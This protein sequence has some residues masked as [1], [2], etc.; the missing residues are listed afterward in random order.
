[1]TKIPQGARA[2]VTGA[3]SGFGRAIALE[4]A[5]RRARVLA[6][7]IDAASL[8]ET[9]SMLRAQGAEA[10]SML[11]DVR[12][13]ARVGA[14][15]E[16]AQEL[17]GGTD[18][19]VNNAGVAVAGEVGEIPLEDWKWQIDINLWGVIHGCHHFVPAMKKQK[20]GWILNVA[21]IAGVTSAP[22]MSP[23]NVTKA[24]VIALSE[25]LATEL[26]S[27]RI[28]VTALCPSFFRTNIHKTTR[29]HRPDAQGRT[30]KLVTEARWGA[31][32]IAR[33]ALAGLDHGRLYVMPQLDA[34]LIWGAKRAFG[35][36]YFSA[37]GALVRLG[38]FDRLM[39]RGG[40]EEHA[41][42]G[43]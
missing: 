24:A 40:S 33:E 9:V 16:R 12:D 29:S 3:G 31:D 11:I 36:G 17:W 6:T 19:L 25:T 39:G 28:T 38:V 7:D 1:M 35:G 13:P 15:A 18:V 27:D 2:V 41:Q 22:M 30:E 20:G 32:E 42:E 4:L 43:R 10:Q 14:M 37:L 5:S 26:A 8:E 34:K 21:S 23:Y